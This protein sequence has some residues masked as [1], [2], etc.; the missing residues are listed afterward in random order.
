MFSSFK[1]FFVEIFSLVL[2]HGNYFVMYSSFHH[3]RYVYL[4]DGLTFSQVVAMTEWLSS[5]SDA[6][7]KRVCRFLIHRYLS[8]FLKSKINLDQMSINLIGGTA[9]VSEVDMDVQV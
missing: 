8:D 4:F 5:F 6:V 2:K 9:T 7:H 3:R 1:F